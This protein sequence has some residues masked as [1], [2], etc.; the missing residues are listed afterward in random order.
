VIKREG[1]IGG[2]INSG[3]KGAQV[4]RAVGRGGT[5]KTG[6]GKLVGKGKNNAGKGKRELAVENRGHDKKKS[7]SR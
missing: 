6:E 1:E 3:K 4:L 2:R 7:V 5:E